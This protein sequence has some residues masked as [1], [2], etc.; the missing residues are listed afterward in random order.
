MFYITDNG[1]PFISTSAGNAYSYCLDLDSWMVVN[2][3]D[4]VSKSG[5]NGAIIS[6]KNMKTYPL[7]TVQYISNSFQQKP[8]SVVDT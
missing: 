5:L 3:S 4:A 6:V 8:K 7:A 2:A 1:I